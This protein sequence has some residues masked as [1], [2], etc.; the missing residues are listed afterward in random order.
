MQEDGKGGFV[1]VGDRPQIS[2]DLTPYKDVKITV[3]G[4]AEDFQSVSIEEIN[5]PLDCVRA[6]AQG[7]LKLLEE[8][9]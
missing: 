9:R 3:A 6:L 8:Q 5:V 2:I 1:V 4:I 7:L